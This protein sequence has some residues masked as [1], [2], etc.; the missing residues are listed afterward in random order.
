[1]SRRPGIGARWFKKYGDG[2]YA[3]DSVIVRARECKPPRYYDRLFKAVRPLDFE[4]IAL[5]REAAAKNLL[6]ILLSA[7]MFVM[8]CFWLGCLV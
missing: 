8:R 1:M 6:T 3:H 2:V 5:A 7:Y 4:R